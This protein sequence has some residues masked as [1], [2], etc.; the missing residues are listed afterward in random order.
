MPQ[1]VPPSAAGLVMRQMR[2]PLRVL[3]Y[4]VRLGCTWCS[5]HDSGLGIGTALLHAAEL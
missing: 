5:H 3:S 4:Q 1:L 2:C